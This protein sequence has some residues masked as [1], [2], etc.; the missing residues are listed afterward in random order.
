MV[1]QIH[2]LLNQAY[3]VHLSNLNSIPRDRLLLISPFGHRAVDCS[4]LDEAIHPV[5]HPLSSSSIKPTYT[6]FNDK[7]VVWDR[8]TSLTEV[9]IGDVRCS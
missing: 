9:K 6:Q 2:L 8:V 1:N 7:K 3:S 5:P 4:S